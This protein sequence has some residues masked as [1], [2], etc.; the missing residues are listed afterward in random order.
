[1][2][3][4]ACLGPPRDQELWKVGS[5]GVSC[6]PQEA[7]KQGAKGT[8]WGSV[9]TWRGVWGQG[10]SKLGS[11]WGSLSSC[12][13][14]GMK[15]IRV[16]WIR[17]V[18]GMQEVL[19]GWGASFMGRLLLRETVA[20]APQTCHGPGPVSWHCWRSLYLSHCADAHGCWRLDTSEGHLLY[21]LFNICLCGWVRSSF[22]VRGIVHHVGS[23]V[24]HNTPNP[25]RL[26]SCRLAQA[27]D[28]GGSVVVTC[29]LTCLMCGILVP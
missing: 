19:G 6:L 21:F 14:W 26:S 7:C 4:D 17:N 5:S 20:H 1:M 16:L 13:L 27:P 8:Q 28:R 15:Q 11:E 24:L 18:P 29:G 22:V 9:R 25:W 2:A 12:L 10:S 23:F 3:L